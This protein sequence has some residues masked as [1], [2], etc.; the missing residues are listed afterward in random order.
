VNP[1]TEKVDEFNGDVQQVR[2]SSYN[3]RDT[4]RCSSHA[5]HTLQF[6]CQ[7]R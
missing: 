2:N 4:E 7:L 3:P 5:L 6:A 1:T